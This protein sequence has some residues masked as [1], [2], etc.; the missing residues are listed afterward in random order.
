MKI[1][2]LCTQLIAES[3]CF[4]KPTRNVLQRCSKALCHGAALGMGTVLPILQREDLRGSWH[5]QLM[6][7]SPLRPQQRLTV[8]LY[9]TEV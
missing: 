4:Q 1:E 9:K 5:L 7:L 2:V 6:P 3:T 8:F